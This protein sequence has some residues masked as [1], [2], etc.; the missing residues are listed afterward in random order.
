MQILCACPKARRDI[1]FPIEK[2]VP[3]QEAATLL[4]RLQEPSSGEDKTITKARAGTGERH[5]AKL[6]R[7]AHEIVMEYEYDINHAQ[8][9]IHIQV[10]GMTGRRVS[11]K[12]GKAARISALSL[13]RITKGKVP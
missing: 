13:G 6:R 9:D 1:L 8:K 7:Q 10:R 2:R 3:T 11:G 12:W 4:T 5:G